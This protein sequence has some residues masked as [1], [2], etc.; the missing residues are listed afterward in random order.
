M[1]DFLNAQPYGLLGLRVIHIILFV[2]L[3]FISATGKE[4]SDERI[5]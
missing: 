4:D 3:V 5:R 2:L 1:I